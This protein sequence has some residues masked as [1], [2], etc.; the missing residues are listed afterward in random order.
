M[1][2]FLCPAP[3]EQLRNLEPTPMQDPG[4][5]A[6]SNAKARPWV[7]MRL[8]RHA[9]YQRVYAATRKQHSSNLSYFVAPRVDG[10]HGPRVGLTVGK[11]LGKAVDRNRIKRRLR[12][13]VR[14]FLP[15]VESDFD[16]ILHPRRAVLTMEF[17]RLSAEMERVFQ[18]IARGRANPARLPSARPQP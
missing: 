11:V 12:E 6:T 2:L 9:D 15:L 17:A 8:R 7:E 3:A 16:I 13:L 1:R 10:G 5:T 4:Q 18:A 14:R